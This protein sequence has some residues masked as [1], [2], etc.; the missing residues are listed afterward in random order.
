[1]SEMV[2]GVGEMRWNKEERERFFFGKCE[3]S[4]DPDFRLKFS[5]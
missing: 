4:G 5:A 1:M 3:V 2:N